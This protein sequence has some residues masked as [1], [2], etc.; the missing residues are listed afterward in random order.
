MVAASEEQ[1]PPFKLFA[2]RTSAIPAAGKGLFLLE[3]V[4]DGKQI[5]RY[6]DD[7]LSKTQTETSNSEYIVQV[8]QNTFLDPN[9]EQHWETA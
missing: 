9:G 6:S 8:S 7:V 3:S 4:K 1:E 5:T 2:I